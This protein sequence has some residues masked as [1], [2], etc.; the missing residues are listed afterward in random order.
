[1]EKVAAFVTR[2]RGAAAE[3]L[4]FAHPSA[5]IQ[6][7]AGTVEIMEQ[8]DSAVLRE[9]WEETGL[10][11]VQIKTRLG[12]LR[13]ELPSDER[14]VLRPTKIFATPASDADGVGFMLFRGSRI[15]HIANHDSFAHI[16]Y[17]EYDLNQ[18]PPVLLSY[19]E[20]FVR[21]SLL[22]RHSV[23]YLYHLV[24][25]SETDPAWTIQADGHLFRCFW[26]PVQPKPKIVPGQQEWLDIV[27]DLLPHG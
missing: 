8:S 11:N 17:D 3:L 16:A 6:L 27:Y 19:I 9:V 23:R 7:P 4:L 12:E 1:M 25:T 18:T 22:T 21:R 26:T 5:G 24:T 14:W 20:G 10:Q 13:R 15:R 2:G